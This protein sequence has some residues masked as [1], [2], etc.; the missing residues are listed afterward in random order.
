MRLSVLQLALMRR[1]VK[2]GPSK[3]AVLDHLKAAH[4]FLEQ[5]K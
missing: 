2:G 5:S 3:E 4:A 1:R